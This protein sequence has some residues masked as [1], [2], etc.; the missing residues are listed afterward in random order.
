M[1]FADLFLDSWYCVSVTLIT[2]SKEELT[3]HIVDNKQKDMGGGETGN[4]C[5]LRDWI[6]L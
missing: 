4:T 2:R 6:P 5:H 3:R 1:T